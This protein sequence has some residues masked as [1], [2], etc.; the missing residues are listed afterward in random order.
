MVLAPQSAPRA[1]RAAGAARD[2]P[3]AAPALS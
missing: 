1:G 2:L 3:E